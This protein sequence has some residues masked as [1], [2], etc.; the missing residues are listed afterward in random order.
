MISSVRLENIQKNLSSN[1]SLNVDRLE[2]HNKYIHVI[3]GPNG[4]GKTTLLRLI[5]LLDKPDRGRVLFN[6]KDVFENDG[7]GPLRR[8]IGFLMQNPYLFDGDVLD[9]VSLGL[10]IRK[11]PNNE[12]RSRVKNIL[13]TW[14]IQHL[15]GQ[16]VKCLSSGE[17]Q[18][19][20]IA[21]V[22]VLEPE[23]ILIDEP[24]ANI[25]TQ[26]IFS[27]E[28]TIRDIQKKVN[29]TII[30][31]THSFTQAYR[32]SSEIISVREGKVVDFVHE[33]VFFGEIKSSTGSLQCMDVSKGVR[34]VFSTE[35]KG[36]SFIAVDPENIIISK[37][38]VKTSARNAFNGIILK[39]ESQGANIRVLIDIGVQIYSIITRQS[40]EEMGINVRS[41]VCVS[42]K[43]NSV[44]VI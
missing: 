27:I 4:S 20:A 37:D 23:V 41:R 42:F 10:K 2:F 3:V 11:Y 44:K 13:R 29:S 24:T 40:F 43:V 14:N 26:S 16:K 21:Q 35:K 32:M 34:I 12:I 15:A 33:N 6:D 28:E 22:L 36:N 38:I 30:M 5:A 31:T 19:V 1:F 18:K 8:R 7:R 39:I 17:Y 9:N 25:D